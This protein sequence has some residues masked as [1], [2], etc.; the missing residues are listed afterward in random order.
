MKGT[1]CIENSDFPDSQQYRCSEM[2]N[3]ASLVPQ[4]NGG[5]SKSYVVS[6]EPA[7]ILHIHKTL[8]ANHKGHPQ[9]F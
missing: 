4:L 5:H 9:N 6:L 8:E 1:A 3:V 7:L 2:V